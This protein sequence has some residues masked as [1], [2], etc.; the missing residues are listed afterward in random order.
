V[1]AFDNLLEDLAAEYGGRARV[2]KSTKSD[3]LRKA[4]AIGEDGVDF[5]VHPS[6]IAIAGLFR[7]VVEV[8]LEQA[9]QIRDLRKGQTELLA[10]L[11]TAGG[12][13]MNKS[14]V[15]G[16][17]ITGDDFMA[18]ALEAQTSGRITGTQVSIAEAYLNAGKAPPVDIL[19]A[20]LSSVTSGSM[21]KQG[22]N[23]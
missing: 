18:K 5:D 16:A 11:E 12:K 2:Q 4:L 15:S 22:L 1:N 6:D 3:D 7:R 19:A 20:V 9:H 14:D 17:R 13:P 23:P 8:V 10:A 21:P